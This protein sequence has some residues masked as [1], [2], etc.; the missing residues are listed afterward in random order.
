MTF[1]RALY[2]QQFQKAGWHLKPWRNLIWSAPAYKLETTACSPEEL[3]HYQEWEGGEGARGGIKG[4]SKAEKLWDKGGGWI[5]DRLWEVRRKKPFKACQGSFK[6]KVG[7]PDLEVCHWESRRLESLMSQLQ[8]GQSSTVSTWKQRRATDSK[9]LVV[10]THLHKIMYAHTWFFCLVAVVSKHATTQTKHAGWDI[11]E[12]ECWVCQ[13][14][15][16]IV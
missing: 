16:Q 5:W 1:T 7:I 8:T 12:C 14:N 9:K 11:W 2:L 15:I 3:W 6:T 13:E 4:G 10:M